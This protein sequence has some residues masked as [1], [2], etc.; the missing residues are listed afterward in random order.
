MSSRHMTGHQEWV[1]KGLELGATA[2]LAALL[3]LE[4]EPNDPTAPAAI[5]KLLQSRWPLWRVEA[6]TQ[7]KL[8]LDLYPCDACRRP[9]AFPSTRTTARGRICPKCLDLLIQ[10]D[11]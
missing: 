9:V 8:A 10:G 1:S 4:L 11:L 2:I 3:E 6:Q 5:S 7:P